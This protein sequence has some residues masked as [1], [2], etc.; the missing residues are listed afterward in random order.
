[1]PPRIFARYLQYF[2]FFSIFQR[3]VCADF[4]MIS[5]KATFCKFARKTMKG[6]CL[7]HNSRRKEYIL[8]RSL[9]GPSGPQLLVCGPSGLLDFVLRALNFVTEGR[10]DEPTVILTRVCMMHVF[11]M[12]HICHACTNLNSDAYI[13]CI[14]YVLCIYICSLIMNA[15]C[16]YIC[17]LIMMHTGMM[18]N[19]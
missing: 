5:I 16:I 11:M 6:N 1:M 10:T 4:H 7:L 18:H 12:R 17:S 15:R 13:H 8:T 3:F 19:R 9:R 14:M 2:Q